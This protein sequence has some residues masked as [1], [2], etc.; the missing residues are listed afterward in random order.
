MLELHN[1]FHMKDTGVLVHGTHVGANGFRQL[2]WVDKKGALGT[3]P[4]AVL[5]ML[6]WGIDRIAVVTI[7]SGSSKDPK[8]NMV[9]SEVLKKLWLDRFENLEDIQKIKESPRWD[10]D[11]AKIR[12]LIEAAIPDSVSVNTRQEI[13]A[14]TEL[15]QKSNIRSVLQIT[16]L[17]RAPRCQSYQ[18]ILRE[19]GVIPA[20]QSWFLVA[21]EVPY[22]G[23]SAADTIVVEYP[24]KDNDQ[25]TK[26]PHNL[27][28][29]SL[30][31]RF[32]Y[33]LKTDDQRIEF[34]KQAS[35]VMKRIEASG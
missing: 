2:A 29:A 18:S 5:A 24:H 34:L 16:C 17:G 33:G 4:T 25:L 23:S 3:L 14:A 8:T 35:D 11:K 28:P 1:G 30:L 12:S 22:T 7:G 26:I 21:D 13:E 31:S 19:N 32:Y 27:L 6:E 20:Q 10:K 9:E 15:F